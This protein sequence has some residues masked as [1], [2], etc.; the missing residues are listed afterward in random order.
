[1]SREISPV[2]IPLPELPPLSV[3]GRKTRIAVAMS[4]GVDSSVVACLL[5]ERGYDLVGFTAWTLNGPGKCCNDALINAGRVCETL[6]M[7]YD[8]VDLRAEFAHYVMDYYKNSYAAGLTPNPCVECNRYI[9]WE[10]LIDY[11]LNELKADYMATGHYARLQHTPE[12]ATQG[13]RVFR[14]QDP[15][16][17]QT[18]MLARVYPKDLNKTIFPLALA[19]K[20]QVYAYA[21]AHDLPTAFSKESQD[22]CFVLNGQQH[23]LSSLFGPT[24]GP[25]V[26]IETGQPLG[27]HDGHFLFTLGQ[28]KGIGIA[29]AHPLYVVKIDAPSNTVFV[30]KK[31][32]LETTVFWVSDVNWLHEPLPPTFESMI[33]IRYNTPPNLGR[34]EKIGSDVK[35]TLH[36][37]QS[38]VTPAQ[39]AAFYDPTNTELWGGGYISTH[40]DHAPFDPEAVSLPSYDEACGLFV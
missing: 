6:G 2:T 18:Y 21:Q 35:V 34:C 15:R 3:D 28:R 24:P 25:I 23:Y 10:K 40:L 36:V 26:D 4:G 8:T 38:A 11:T 37:P 30:G 16:K 9:K 5:A 17:D 7:P 1:M 22:V 20:D 39:I 12:G 14:A 29:A 19:T 27:T 31:E 13:V 33:K 32:H